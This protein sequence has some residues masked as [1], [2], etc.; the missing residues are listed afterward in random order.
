M[1]EVHAG[2]PCS[3]ARLTG[4]LRDPF[5]IVSSMARAIDATISDEAIQ[6]AVANRVKRFGAALIDVPGRTICVL[7]CL[8]KKGKRLGLIS[9]ADV[10][11]VAEW[12]KSP[13]AGLFDSTVLSCHVGVAKPDR[14]IYEIC[15]RQLDVSPE[16]AVFVGDGGSSEL[17]GAHRMGL[18]TVMVT[19]IIKELW[20]ERIESRKVDADYAIE[21]LSELLDGDFGMHDNGVHGEPASALP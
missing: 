5:R 4:E 14:E 11:E 17:T 6:S 15:L 9:T 3:R 2:G 1:G 12:H 18:T 10:M 20:P 21:R 19:G 7:Q 8:K 13:M 16:R